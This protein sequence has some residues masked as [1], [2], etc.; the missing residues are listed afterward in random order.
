MWRS[1]E[2]TMRCA[3][4]A[5]AI[6]ALTARG[7]E[8]PG[9]M[10][11]IAPSRQNT[12][13]EFL[14]ALDRYHEAASSYVIGFGE[15]MD[16]WLSNRFRDPETRGRTRQ[17]PLVYDPQL[18]D[19]ID[20]SRVILSPIFDF[21]EKQGLSPGL[22]AK[23]RLRFPQLSERIDLIFDSD[24]DDTDVTPAVARANDTGLRSGDAGAATLRL[25]LPDEFKF[26]TSIEAGLKFKPEPVPRLGVRLRL[27]KNGDWFNS[28]FTQTF[29]WETEDG[30]GERS[31]LDFEQ[32][33]PNAYL[34]RL[35]TSVLWSEGTDGV[36]G[37]QTLQ[38]YRFL[39]N[40]RAI[41]LK[42]G[43]EGPLEP[44]VHVE[45]YSTRVSWRQKVHR[46]WM[47]IEFEPGIDWPR[48]EDYEAVAVFRVK[49][50]I[51]IGDWLEHG[52]GK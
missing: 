50:D 33:K 45:R 38:L 35:S 29:F 34:R 20:G 36:R 48:D 51:V 1:W 10:K 52:E 41:G 27:S 13:R 17:I 11:H 8:T 28:R 19:D 43:V 2:T 9:P 47:F 21:R 12:G 32:I 7:E 37:G 31:S 24:F 25:R 49:L 23:G 6:F 22:K 42:L 15:G 39:S 18:L 26:R 44:S 3:A 46:D 4:C 16:G 30:W 14:D 40:R 5:L